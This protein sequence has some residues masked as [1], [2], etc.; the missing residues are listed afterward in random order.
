MT[1]PI[2][3]VQNQNG[4]NPQTTQTT[5]EIDFNLNLPTNEVPE[6][7]EEPVISLDFEDLEKTQID[8]PQQT[9]VNDSSFVEEKKLGEVP[10]VEG[11]VITTPNEMKEEVIQAEAT[12]VVETTSVVEENVIASNSVAIQTETTPVVET[13]PVIE[14][15]PVI[16]ENTP[17]VEEP[18]QI[19]S[20]QIDEIATEFIAPQQPEE[21]LQQP[22][23]KDNRLE[24]E[25]ALV[26]ENKIPIS[27]PVVETKEVPEIKTETLNVFEEIPTSGEEIIKENNTNNSETILSEE[28]SVSTTE[29]TPIEV[30]QLK[31][32]EILQEKPVPGQPEQ[33][34]P[35]TTN[36]QQDQTIIQQLQESAWKP[37][38]PIVSAP[39]ATKT[40]VNLDDLLNSPTPQV[41]NSLPTNNVISVSSVGAENQNNI[42]TQNVMPAFTWI[43]W[44]SLPPIASQVTQQLKKPLNKKILINFGIGIIALC[45]GGFMFKTMY[46]LEYQKIMGNT[47]ESTIENELTNTTIPE[48]TTTPTDGLFENPALANYHAAAENTGNAELTGTDNNFNAF[49]DIEQT[50]NQD[51]TKVKEQLQNY[52]DQ[53][54]KYLVI[55][56][57]TNDKNITKYGLFLYKKA[58][59]LL[60]DIENGT[61]ISTDEINT[62]LADFETYLQ[63]LTG[64]GSDEQ[65]LSTQPTTPTPEEFFWSEN[66]WTIEEE[67]T[68][69]EIPATT[70]SWTTTQE[71][72]NAVENL[73]WNENPII[74]PNDLNW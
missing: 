46:P 53:W 68:T 26:A 44:Y 72:E 50:M 67:P 73:S 56:K 15:A 62:Q 71:T 9:N 74:Q 34:F 18:I 57:R 17:I 1:D 10:V 30:Q 37:I 55:G 36:L 39:V 48:E 8:N 2:V 3:Q 52:V 49:E 7:K 54:K 42:P 60:V 32:E 23:N 25:D 70:E 31:A 58:S 24:Q 43:H 29:T 27:T 12:P 20:N 4:Q 59:V 33:N 13:T 66:S 47:P 38:E 69:T 21:T 14:I 35:P 28:I 45:I 22:E 65:I 19:E 6:T 63:K 61:Q 51:M 11:N 16:Q 41:Q 64:T 5:P 40:E